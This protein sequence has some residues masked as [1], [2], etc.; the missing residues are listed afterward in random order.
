MTS[1]PGVQ[2]VQNQIAAMPATMSKAQMIKQAKR[3]AALFWSFRDDKEAH[4]WLYSLVKYRRGRLSAAE[5]CVR[6]GWVSESLFPEDTF[7]VIMENEFP[8]FKYK[9]KPTKFVYFKNGK[10]WDIDR[11]AAVTV[12]KVAKKL[13]MKV[14]NVAKKPVMKVAKVAKKPAANVIKNKGKK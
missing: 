11:L 12:Q 6:L 14:R 13:A 1:S 5:D 2:V 8:D 3:D 10:A 9:D 7:H 4:E